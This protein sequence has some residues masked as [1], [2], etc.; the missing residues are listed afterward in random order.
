LGTG[1]NDS[2]N[3]T[4]QSKFYNRQQIKIDIHKDIIYESYISGST[5]PQVGRAMGKTRY[6]STSSDGTITLPSNHVNKFSYPFKDTMY[7]GSQNTNP[8]FLQVKQEDYSSA[9]FYRAKVTGGE[10]EIVIRKGK[11][12]IDDNDRIIYS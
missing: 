11:G 5:G 4:N 3:F 12:N 7:M 6:F 9:S 8:G 1:S 2:S 10:N